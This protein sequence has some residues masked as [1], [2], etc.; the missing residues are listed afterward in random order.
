MQACTYDAQPSRT[1]RHSPCCHADRYDRIESENR[2]LLSK[3]HDIIRASNT[4][5]SLGLKAGEEAPGPRSLNIATRRADMDRITEEN[6]VRRSA[7][8]LVSPHQFFILLPFYLCSRV[9]PTRA[10]RPPS[11][12]ACAGSAVSHSACAQPLF[13]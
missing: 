12:D 3:M 8:H 10:G 5:G 7:L 13:D 2:I 9:M 6:L 1:L 4:S 11:R